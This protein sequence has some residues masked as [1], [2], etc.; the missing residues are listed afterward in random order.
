MF[1]TRIVC[2][3]IK[4]SG[5]KFQ[6]LFQ[7]Q[8]IYKKFKCQRNN[9]QGQE[10]QHPSKL[11]WRLFHPSSQQEIETFQLTVICLKADT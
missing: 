10:M 4:I 6:D 2:A 1:V 7:Y 5:N 9:C 3:K 8:K 11:I